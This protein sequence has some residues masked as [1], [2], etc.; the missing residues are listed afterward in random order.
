VVKKGLKLKRLEAKR[1]KKRERQRI[2]KDKN[3]SRR[4]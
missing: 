3:L 4:R 2:M 1:S